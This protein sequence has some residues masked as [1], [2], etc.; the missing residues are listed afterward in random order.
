MRDIDP[1]EPEEITAEDLEQVAGGTSVP[2]GL[3]LQKDK[4]N[5]TIKSNMIVTPT[6]K[7]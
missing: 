3:G 4:M 7:L 5:P 1:K 2:I 6:I